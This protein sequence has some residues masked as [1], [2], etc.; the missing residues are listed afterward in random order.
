MI[1]SIFNFLV[2]R[3]Q[4]QKKH[5]KDNQ[6][7]KKGYHGMDIAII[8]KLFTYRPMSCL[9]FL[10]HFLSQNNHEVKEPQHQK[11]IGIPTRNISKVDGSGV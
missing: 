10:K 9:A 11:T 7:I 1:R 5:S 8:K 2:K 6:T 3:Q 4:N